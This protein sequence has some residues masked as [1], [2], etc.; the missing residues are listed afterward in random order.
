MNKTKPIRTNYNIMIRRRIRNI[1]VIQIIMNIMLII[2]RWS[3][4]EII[5][6]ILRIRRQRR[7]I[8]IIRILIMTRR[9]TRQI[10][11]IITLIIIII[12]RI[13]RGRTR[14]TG[15]RRRTIAIIRTIIRKKNNRTNNNSN[16]N[17]NKTVTHYE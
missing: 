1:H 16:K 10:I 11:T 2:R 13:I 3:N 8:H 4:P 15:I 5:I 12:R 17:R 7:I 9:A 6:C 14:T